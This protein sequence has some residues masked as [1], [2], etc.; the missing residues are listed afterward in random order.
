MAKHAFRRLE[1]LRKA[2][3][4]TISGSTSSVCRGRT[5][6]GWHRC[7]TRIRFDDFLPLYGWYE[8]DVFLPPASSYGA[9]VQ[10]LDGFWCSP[11]NKR[12]MNVCLSFALFPKLP[13]RSIWPKR[14]GFLGLCRRQRSFALHPR[15]CPR[16][17]TPE[18]YVDLRGSLLGISQ[19]VE[20]CC[21]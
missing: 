2:N 17:L 12:R 20:N 13:I 16:R 21:I 7:A 9:I 11:R 19:P 3:L 14:L 8:E 6:I 10:S 1:A 18:P 15:T 5:H 4:A